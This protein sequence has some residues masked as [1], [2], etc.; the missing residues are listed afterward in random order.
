MGICGKERSVESRLWDERHGW[1]KAWVPSTC[2]AACGCSCTALCGAGR[3]GSSRSD[4]R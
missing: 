2:D 1:R 3:D 4:S